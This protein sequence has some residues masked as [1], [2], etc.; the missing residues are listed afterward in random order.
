MLERTP[1]FFTFT[2]STKPPTFDKIC[3]EQ[4]SASICKKSLMT[5]I[6]DLFISKKNISL[7]IGVPKSTFKLSFIALKSINIMY[8]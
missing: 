1:F 4:A 3:E 2:D 7:L 6:H 5:C 8:A